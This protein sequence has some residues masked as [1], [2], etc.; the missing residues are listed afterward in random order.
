MND[1]ES[2]LRIYLTETIEKIKDFTFDLAAVNEND[3][4]LNKALQKFDDALETNLLRLENQNIALLFSGGIDSSILAH[5]MNQLKIKYHAILVARS[6]SELDYKNA[7][8]VSKLLNIELNILTLNL[9]GYE[10]ILPLIM[11]IINSTDEKQVNISAPFFLIA[12]YLE[13]HNIK[14]AVLGQCADELFCGYQRYV[15]FLLTDPD[16]FKTYHLQDIKKSILNNFTRDNLIFSSKN[17]IIFYPYLSDEILKMSLS[18]PNEILIDLT[19]DPPEKKHFLRLYAQKLKLSE[20]IWQKK[21][22]AIQFGSGSYKILR[23]I[24]LKHGFTKPFSQE[25]GYLRHVQL[26]LDYLAQNQGIRD[27]NIKLKNQPNLK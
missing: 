7:I 11:K 16:N 23:K 17:I 4:D 6:R 18:I 24:A 13:K 9:E 19:K 10:K 5:K 1:I 26:Y 2:Q 21:K 12:D 25:H 14:V 15:D 20:R 8:E 27:F 22:V 3:F